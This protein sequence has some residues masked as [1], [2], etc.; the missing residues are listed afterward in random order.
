M[1]FQTTLHWLYI[2]GMTIVALHFWS[3]SRDPK[4]V[5]QSEYL[6]AI[7]IPIWSGLTI[8]CYTFWES[9]MPCYQ[10]LEPA[11]AKLVVDRERFK[12]HEKPRQIDGLL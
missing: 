9:L 2:A 6:V 5:P 11:I 7:F 8:G 1:N 3:L 10:H 12:D 4:G